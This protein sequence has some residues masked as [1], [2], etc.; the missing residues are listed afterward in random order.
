MNGV[1]INTAI[2]ASPPNVI[3]SRK[4]KKSGTDNLLATPKGN[5]QQIR[6]RRKIKFTFILQ[7]FFICIVK[8]PL[9]K[10]NGGECTMQWK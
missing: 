5:L 3:F 4:T 2:N 8:L 1:E 6:T 10:D 7:L 9:F